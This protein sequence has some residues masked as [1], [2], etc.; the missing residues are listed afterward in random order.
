MEYNDQTWRWCKN[1]CHYCHMWC[2]QENCMSHKEY[3]RSQEGKGKGKDEDKKA[4][5]NQDFRVV[6][7]A[8]VMCN[9]FKT[10]KE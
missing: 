6:L 5:A 8:M 10:F 2:P 9:E 4:H 3:K 1:D 7:V